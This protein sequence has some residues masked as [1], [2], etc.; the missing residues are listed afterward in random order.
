M[1]PAVPLRLGDQ[2][3]S[4]LGVAPRP[5]LVGRDVDHRASGGRAVSPGW[6]SHRR[7]GRRPD[8]CRAVLF[9]NY[10]Y[11]H[12]YPGFFRSSRCSGREDLCFGNHGSLGETERALLSSTPLIDVL[13]DEETN[14]ASRRPTTRCTSPPYL[15]SAGCAVR[16][17]PL[18]LSA[19][20]DGPEYQAA[21]TCLFDR[22][23]AA[24][25]R[26]LE[27]DEDPVIIIQ[28]DHGPRLGVG[29]G[30]SDRVLLDDEMYFSAFSAIRLPE[31]CA[32][33][34]VPDDLT[35][36]NTF[37]IV[38]A[39]LEDRSPTLLPDRIFPIERIY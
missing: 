3:R 39:C 27:V 21:L 35:I 23:E 14:G 9:F 38:F 31:P 4:G 32:E 20:G 25:N 15:R 2:R 33:V 29:P 22:M 17:V 13:V 7:L 24:G 37:R 26:I 10:R 36:V 19:W 6:T 30:I 12:A 18:A 11:A 28:G 5:D 1:E 34:E 8:R 16:D